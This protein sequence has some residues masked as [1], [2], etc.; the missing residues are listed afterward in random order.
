MTMV[1]FILEDSGETLSTHSRLGLIGLLLTKTKLS[2]RFSNLKMPKIAFQIY[3]RCDNL[4]YR[5]PISR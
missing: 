5:H 2:K 4:I 1:K 3:W